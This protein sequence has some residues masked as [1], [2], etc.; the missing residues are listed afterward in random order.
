MTDDDLTQSLKRMSAGDT[1]AAERVAS[2]V[3]QELH[4]LAA[5]ALAGA[6]RDH[7]LQ[8]TLLVNEAFLRLLGASP[9]AWQDRN[10]FRRT[11]A[12]MMRRIIVDYFRSRSASKRPPKASRIELDDNFM[13]SDDRC[14]E[15]L[16]VHEALDK[17]AQIDA[18]AANVVELRFFG[19]LTI[20]ETAEVLGV[21]DKTVQRDWEMAQWWLKHH[22]GSRADSAHA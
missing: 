13:F 1:G 20:D 22:F 10:H 7:S 21:V 18:R 16:M 5:V 19:G 9:V 6:G 8:P 2:L 17:L 14:D 15:A 3:Y 12:R 4:R 11:A